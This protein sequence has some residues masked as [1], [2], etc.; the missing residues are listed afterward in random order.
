[1]KLH[2]GCGSIYLD[3]YVN[4]D[5][6]GYMPSEISDV[7]P[8]TLDSYY[9]V[10]FQKEFDKRNRRPPVIDKEMDLHERWP[11]EDGTVEEIVMVCCIEHHSKQWARFISNEAHRV[12]RQGGKWLV[13]FPDIKQAF[14][15]Y[16]ESD[17]EFFFELVFC[18][19]KDEYSFH[20]WGY[21]FDTFK[22]FLGSA[23]N[24]VLKDVV[25]HDYPM[26]GVEATKL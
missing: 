12:L 8:A 7:R 17:P 5:A 9:Q 2:L 1:V 20:R 4:C 14:D 6:W 26:I 24:V 15:N 25:K 18:N 22:Q 11:F 13:D 16:F 3:G 19:G 10:P 23:W 21:T